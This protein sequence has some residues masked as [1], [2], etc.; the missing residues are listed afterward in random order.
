MDPFHVVRLA[1]DNLTA[2]RQRLQRE[3]YHRC[4]VRDEPLYKNQK[5]LLTMQQ[6]LSDEQQARLGQM[7]SYDKDYVV[8]KIDWHAYHG[9]IDCYCMRSKRA[10]CTNALLMFWHFSMLGS[11][12]GLSKR[13]T[14]ASSIFAELP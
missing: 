8:L 2:C 14:G 6:W 5:T 7:W 1:G 10:A 9:I 12:T 4:G 3:K 11:L 13:S